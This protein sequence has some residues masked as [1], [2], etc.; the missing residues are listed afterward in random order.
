MLDPITSDGNHIHIDAFR[1][2][3]QEVMMAQ[4]EPRHTT[5]NLWHIQRPNFD[6][7]NRGLDRSYYNIV[8]NYKKNEFE[9][10]MLS[11]LN[12]QSWTN[13]L[14]V[15][16]FATQEAQNL[17]RLTQLEKLTG[18]YSKWIKQESSMKREEFVVSQT[19]KLNP[20]KRLEEEIEETMNS[21]VIDCLGTMLNTVCF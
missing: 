4:R 8:I 14:K 3:P 16:D 19:G 13:S 2:I 10:R 5:S 11:N 18:H 7:M 21:N 6:A 12:K 17:D 9:Q 1:T 20:K 15:T